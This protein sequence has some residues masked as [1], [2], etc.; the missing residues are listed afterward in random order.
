MYPHHVARS[1]SA[2]KLM[3]FDQDLINVGI[4]LHFPNIYISGIEE[5]ETVL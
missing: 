3:Y 1:V 4:F 5:I 2:L